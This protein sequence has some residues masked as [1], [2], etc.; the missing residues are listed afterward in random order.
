MEKEITKE[1]ARFFKNAKHLR[2]FINGAIKERRQLMDENK[3]AKS[4]TDVIGILL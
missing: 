4:A 2:N 3:Q 1:D